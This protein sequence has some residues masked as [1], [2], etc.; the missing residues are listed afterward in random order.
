MR[1]G[2]PIAIKRGI[3]T[4]YECLCVP[5]CVGHVLMMSRFITSANHPSPELLS[6]ARSSARCK[7]QLG[8]SWHF[9]MI[10][11]L[12]CEVLWSFSSENANAGILI[13]HCRRGGFLKSSKQD[14]TASTRFSSPQNRTPPQSESPLNGT[15]TRQ[16]QELCSW[17]YSCRVHVPLTFCTPQELGGL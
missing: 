2:E 12:G 13:Q 7:G 16:W 6:H 3:R 15:L 11:I 8:G 5:V 1:W 4:L 10:V 17:A 9:H 14:G